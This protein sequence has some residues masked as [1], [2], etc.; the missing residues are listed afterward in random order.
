MRRSLAVA[1]VVTCSGAAVACGGP[2]ALDVGQDGGESTLCTSA[3]RPGDWTVASHTADASTDL[4]IE[5]LEL[6]GADGVRLEESSLS[7]LD[8]PTTI[9]GTSPGWPGELVDVDGPIW[10]DR[11]P[12][13]GETMAKGESW[14]LVLRVVVEEVPATL[15]GIRV[16]YRSG[17]RSRAADT[18]M[19][20]EW[21]ETCGP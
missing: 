2:P 5:E 12:A 19:R 20:I 9:P 6:V 10:Q 15:E 14:V 18:S 3:S 11:R 13:E 7:T 8:G 4:E 1:V 16:H 17:W 21:R